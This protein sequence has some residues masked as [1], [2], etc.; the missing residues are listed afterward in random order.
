VAVQEGVVEDGLGRARHH[1]VDLFLAGLGL[2]AEL[3]V[4][5]GGDVPVAGGAV[6]DGDR[7]EGDAQVHVARGGEEG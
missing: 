2:E 5:G 6:L 3:A 4:G 7:A 1:E